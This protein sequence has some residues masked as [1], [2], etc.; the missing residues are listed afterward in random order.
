MLHGVLIAIGGL[1]IGAS[2]GLL[3]GGGTILALPLLLALGVEVKQAIAGSLAVVAA[4]A[5]VAAAHH[6]RAGNVDWRSAAL[7]GPATVLGAYAAGRAAGRVSSQALLLVFTGLMIGA[8]I[9][10]LLRRPAAPSSVA[11]RPLHPAVLAL[12][13]AA[14]GA[15]TGLVGAGGGFLYVPTFALFGR[16]PMT[17]AVGTSLVVIAASALAALVGHLS[18]VALRIDVALP[19]TGAAMAGAWLGAGLAGRASEIWLRRAFGS[20]ILVVAAWLLVHSF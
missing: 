17:K 5:C 19:L 1:A 8:G 18:H 20:F 14:I 16:M 2:L 7:F 10:M 15:L 9:S 3:G 4:T 13:G 12:Q 6:T 11:L